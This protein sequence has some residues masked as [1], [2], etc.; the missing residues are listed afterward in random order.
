MPDEFFNQT[1]PPA[2]R[3]PSRSGRGF[4]GIALLAFL[5]GAGAVGYAAW[6][7]LVPFDHARPVAKVAPPPSTTTVMPAPP[8]P[9][10]QALAEQD[11]LESRMAL[12]EQRLTQLDLRAEAASGNAARAEG[13]LVAFAARRALDRGT[14]L[15]YLEDQLR[16]RFSD[17]QPNAVTTIIDSAHNP[18][19]IDQLIAGL[20]TLTPGLTN[21]PESGDAWERFKSELA[22]LFVIRHDTGPTI[23]PET[24]VARART[25]LTAGKIEAAIA[26]V[27][28]LPGASGARGWIDAARRYDAGQ[29]ALDLIE[30]TAM[31][32]TRN[33][34]DGSGQSVEQPSPLAPPQP[35]AAAEATSG[36][37]V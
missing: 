14:P 7:G 6:Q 9:P 3:R 33:L 25:L 22:G 11:A 18:V 32:E 23:A 21:A 1:P 37:A 19:T 29:R 26:E 20:D 15:G 35:T 24:R 27:Q 36:G 13:L 17:A 34:K 2:T 5:L 28:R 12:L 8:A 10:P 16:L 30:T 31:L 4:V